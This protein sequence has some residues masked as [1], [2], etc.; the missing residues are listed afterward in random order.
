[1]IKILMIFE[2]INQIYE[3][4]KNVNLIEKRENEIICQKPTIIP[5]NKEKISI[6][7]QKMM[8]YKN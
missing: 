3:K 4:N 5:E 2:K 7:F 6:T 8:N 1:M